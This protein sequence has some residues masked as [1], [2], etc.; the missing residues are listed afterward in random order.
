[1]RKELEKQ[2]DIIEEAKTAIRSAIMVIG[3]L[4]TITLDLTQADGYSEGYD[5]GY[6]EAREF[7]TNGKNR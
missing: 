6:A 2:L 3:R 7:H 1:M 4:E 5:D